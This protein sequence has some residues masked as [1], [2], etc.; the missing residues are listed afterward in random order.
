MRVERKRS[1]GEVNG[2]RQG[3]RR[4]GG[5][6]ALVSGDVCVQA[7]CTKG[8]AENR[9]AQKKD[10]RKQ[11]SVGMREAEQK[12]WGD[13]GSGVK[14]TQVSVGVRTALELR[15]DDE[16]RRRRCLHAVYIYILTG[17]I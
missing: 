7:P 13:A 5:T 9:C 12:R 15:V 3:Q 14:V 6:R 4:G 10:A 1:R 8:V 16:A 11:W 17:R 2:R